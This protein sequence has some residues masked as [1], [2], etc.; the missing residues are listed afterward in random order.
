[1]K[2]KTKTFIVILIFTY[3]YM[4]SAYCNVLKNENFNSTEYELFNTA[5]NLSNLKSA[6]LIKQGNNA[7][8]PWFTRCCGF[9]TMRNCSEYEDEFPLE[10][11]VFDKTKLIS[12]PIGYFKIVNEVNCARRIKLE[13]EHD[14]KWYLQKNGQLYHPQLPHQP[15]II[16]TSPQD[17]CLDF[18][19]NENYSLTVNAYLCITS[20][21]LEAIQNNRQPQMYVFGK[22][23]ILIK[24]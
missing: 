20:Q 12:V 22:Y 10:N 4:N 24:H 18:Y 6:N 2:K 9:S 3:C 15:D 17:Y 11:M 19:Q 7:N 23:S 5:D 16:Y 14:E 21:V 1:M 13:E 8:K